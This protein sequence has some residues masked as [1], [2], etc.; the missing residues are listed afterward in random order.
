MADTTEALK[1]RYDNNLDKQFELI[2]EYNQLK[3]KIASLRAENRMIDAM[4]S[5]ARSKTQKRPISTL[6][7]VAI[8]DIDAFVEHCEKA[9]DATF[10]KIKKDVRSGLAF[11]MYAAGYKRQA[12]ADAIGVNVDT[13]Q[14]WKGY[15]RHDNESILA[16]N[17]ILFTYKSSS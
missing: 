11:Y 2:E 10:T 5:E 4:L 12:I 14:K 17:S 8:H 3:V 1:L 15:F 16:I 13:V 6:N 9:C 7:D